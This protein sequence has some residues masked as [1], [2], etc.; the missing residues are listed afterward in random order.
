MKKSKKRK[1]CLIV[2]VII[3][4]TAFFIGACA[5]NH[6]IDE[7]KLPNL[8]QA[9]E[10]HAQNPNQTSD[11]GADAGADADANANSDAIITEARAMKIALDKVP[12]ASEKDITS[13][14][15]EYDYGRWIYDGEIRYEGL[16]YDFEIDARTGNILEWEIDD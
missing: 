6:P 3:A 2:C 8:G 16:E 5:N 11:I 10:T 12:G 14:G 13:F 15:R 1:Q 9:S 4:L 7:S